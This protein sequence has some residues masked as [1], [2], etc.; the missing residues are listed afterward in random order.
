MKAKRI[1]TGGV[2]MI[3]LAV[4]SVSAQEPVYNVNVAS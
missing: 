3:L 1:F 4:S 2:F